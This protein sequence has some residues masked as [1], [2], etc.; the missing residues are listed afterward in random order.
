VSSTT[1]SDLRNLGADGRSKS[2]SGVTF[3]FKKPRGEPAIEAK[4][5]NLHFAQCQEACDLFGAI[6]THRDYLYYNALGRLRNREQAED[7]VQDSFVA[8]LGGTEKFCGKSSQ[9]TWLTAIL[10]HKVCDQMRRACRERTIFESGES[11]DHDQ[12]K[13]EGGFSL[14]CFSNPRTELERKELR[15]AIEQAL[16][17]LPRRLAKAFSLYE[18]DDWSSREVCAV[19]KISQSNLWI[20]LHR[21]RKQLRGHLSSWNGFSRRKYDEKV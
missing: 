18:I 3:S 21:A 5:T 10:K 2:N 11:T 15:M 6:E 9:R 20:I 1:P 12:F 19:L 14:L 8:A 17:K 13:G 7:A 4:R 16:A